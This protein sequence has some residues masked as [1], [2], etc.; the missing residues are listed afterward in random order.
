VSI[1]IL[2]FERNQSNGSREW[3]ECYQAIFWPPRT[4]ASGLE[5]ISRITEILEQTNLFGRPVLIATLLLIAMVLISLAISLHVLIR[6]PFDYLAPDRVQRFD[7]SGRGIL[8]RAG[9][10]LKNLLGA[11][12]VVFGVMLSLP[13]IPGQ[14]L[15]TVLAGVLL[16]DFPGKRRLLSKVLRRPPVLRSINRL[17]TRFS[18]PP[19]VVG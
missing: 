3:P 2:A 5:V 7:N 8:S 10:V 19:L 4:T 14:G 11:A 16:L 17:R 6:L 1:S 9:I 12:L 13:G 15:L 18:R